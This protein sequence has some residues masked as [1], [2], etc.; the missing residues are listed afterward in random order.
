MRTLLLAGLV[1]LIAIVAFVRIEV[2]RE[3][4]RRIAIA[5]TCWTKPAYSL[6]VETCMSAHGYRFHGKVGCSASFPSRYDAPFCYEPVDWYWRQ[7]FW[8]GQDF[9]VFAQE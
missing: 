8:I 5:E 1:C 3:T 9:T 4:S 7:M 2:D 6:S